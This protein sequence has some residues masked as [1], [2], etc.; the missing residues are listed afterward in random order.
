MV[1]DFHTHAFPDALAPK[2]MAVLTGNL[3]VELHPVRDGRLGSLIEFMDKWNID[4]SVIA[5]IVT[6]PTQI[7]S[8]NEWAA[9]CASERIVPLGSIFPTSSTYREDIDFVCSLG[10]KGIKLHAEYQDFVPDTP[11][12]LKVYDYAF[13]KGLIILQHA[14][15]DY[16]M[17]E[18]YKSNPEKFAHIA[19]EMKGGVMVAAH[20]GGYMQWQDVYDKLC[21][22][23]IYFDT[24]MGF[25]YYGND[26]FLRIV[27][28]HG[29]DKILFG[30]DSPW[31]HAGHEV[32]RLRNCG[33]DSD[34]IEKIT[35]KNAVRILGL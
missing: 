28:K 16:G 34:S 8:L 7:K 13:S 5:P 19:D 22:K 29:A 20:L 11:H 27:Q 21:G 31:S 10:L 2:A 18:P 12:M 4:K 33:L 15:A 35:H 1:I 14:G 6:K 25:E 24:S 3:R 32:E 26:M 17:P 9:G 23:N 30:S